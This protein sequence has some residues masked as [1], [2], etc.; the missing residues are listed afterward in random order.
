MLSEITVWRQLIL[1][2]DGK[3]DLEGRELLLAWYFCR[4]WKLALFEVSDTFLKWRSLSFPAP[5]S[6]LVRGM[7]RKKFLRKLSAINFKLRYRKD[8]DSWYQEWGKGES[9]REWTGNEQREKERKT[10]PR[11]CVFSASVP[12]TYLLIHLNMYLELMLVPA[13][14]MKDPWMVSVIYFTLP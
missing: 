5:L 1:I 11:H 12:K 10:L 6:F 4:L 14:K 3:M 13:E 2:M 8:F 9:H 7:W